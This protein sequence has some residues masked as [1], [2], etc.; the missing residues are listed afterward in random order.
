MH[1]VKFDLK[2]QFSELDKLRIETEILQIFEFMFEQ[3]GERA[4]WIGSSGFYVSRATE[5]ISMESGDDRA[6]MVQV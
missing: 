6:E 4:R 3:W 5:A 2:N 1:F